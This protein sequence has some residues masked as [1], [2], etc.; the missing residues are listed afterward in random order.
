LEGQLDA[1]ADGALHALFAIA[2]TM[3]VA[4]L[5]AAILRA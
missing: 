4:K 5:V 3:K 1:L 2:I